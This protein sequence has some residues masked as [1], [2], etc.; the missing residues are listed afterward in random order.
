[1]IEKSKSVLKGPSN[2]LDD[3]NI[4]SSSKKLSIAKLQLKKE[5]LIEKYRQTEYYKQRKDKRR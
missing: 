4:K 5:A 1:M 2:F 3:E